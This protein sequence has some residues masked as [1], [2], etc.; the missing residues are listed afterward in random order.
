MS[1]LTVWP[2]Q[3][4][5]LVLAEGLWGKVCVYKLV[6]W[7][8]F[9]WWWISSISWLQE[10]IHVC[11]SI[12]KVIKFVRVSVNYFS[13]IDWI[14]EAINICDKVLLFVESGWKALTCI[15]PSIFVY[16]FKF[17]LFLSF[18]LSR[19]TYTYFLLNHLIAKCKYVVTSPQNTF[20]HFLNK[21][22]LSLNFSNHLNSF[23]Y[24]FVIASMI[25]F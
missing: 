17:S 16:A 1:R 15:I 24:K 19:H 11:I 13:N 23:L 5:N 21:I 8:W 2:Q 3:G 18:C 12:S 9:L 6:E 20:T 14:N 10:S 4:D 22:T 7:G 25:T